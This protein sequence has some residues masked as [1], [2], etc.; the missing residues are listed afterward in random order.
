[1]DANAVRIGHA[2]GALHTQ[3]L[4]FELFIMVA[5]KGQIDAS[6]QDCDNSK[7]FKTELS[8]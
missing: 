7:I 3:A 1:M 6:V 2:E 4:G 8:A 5:T